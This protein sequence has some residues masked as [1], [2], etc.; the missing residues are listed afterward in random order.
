MIIIGGKGDG[1]SRTDT[2]NFMIGED[3]QIKVL[4]NPQ[5]TTNVAL[6]VT[7]MHSAEVIS[8]ETRHGSSVEFWVRPELLGKYLRNYL[9][10]TIVRK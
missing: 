9:I 5:K 7:H 3:L 8:S 2:D 10:L 6:S 4:L 1:F